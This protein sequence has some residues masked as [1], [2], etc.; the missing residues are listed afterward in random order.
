M[1]GAAPRDGRRDQASWAGGGAGHVLR[2]LLDSFRLKGEGLEASDWVPGT[3]ARE[4][5]HGALRPGEGL[6][7]AWVVLA[8]ER[9]WQLLAEYMQGRAWEE[10][11]LGVQQHS[12]DSGAH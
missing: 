10:G 12:L 8:G 6:R 5:I 1:L 11:P 3:E 7:R 4:E 2:S 9:L